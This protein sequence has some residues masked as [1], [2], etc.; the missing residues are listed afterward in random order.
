[1]VLHKS[2]HSLKS[3]SSPSENELHLSYAI[4]STT[5]RATHEIS[6]TLL[7]LPNTRQLADAHISGL[8][9]NS[10]MSDVIGARVQSNDVPGLI[11]VVL[12]RARAEVG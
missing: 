8:P 4:S 9:S 11:A 12:A 3:Y 5:G 1:L 10:D 2:L 6:I 7:F